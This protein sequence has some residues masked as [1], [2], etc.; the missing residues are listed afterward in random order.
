MGKLSS[1]ATEVQIRAFERVS[2][3]RERWLEVRNV[4]HFTMR[5]RWSWRNQKFRAH[6]GKRWKGRGDDEE[7]KCFSE[8]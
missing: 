3:M 1:S 6:L 5:D 7:R 8:L 4:A 2:A